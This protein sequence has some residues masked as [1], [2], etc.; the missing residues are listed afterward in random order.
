M[1][2]DELRRRRAQDALAV[3][4]RQRSVPVAGIQVPLLPASARELE[5]L[6][7]QTAL[8]AATE[9]RG[10]TAPSSTVG[11]A[12]PFTPSILV[13]T[14]EARYYLAARRSTL[15]AATREVFVAYGTLQATFLPTVRGIDDPI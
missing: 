13:V 9:V 15:P 3:I 2:L 5:W 7:S 11:V 14:Y 10:Q 1:R 8:L 4:D 12:S 6:A